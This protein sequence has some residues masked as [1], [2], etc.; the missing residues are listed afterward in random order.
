MGLKHLAVLLNALSLQ[1]WTPPAAGPPHASRDRAMWPKRAARSA[2][3]AM[4]GMGG[5]ARGHAGWE[6]GSGVSALSAEIGTN[7]VCGPP[8]SCEGYFLGRVPLPSRR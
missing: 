6:R 2:G 3:R 5:R 7:S 1:P 8:S 4:R